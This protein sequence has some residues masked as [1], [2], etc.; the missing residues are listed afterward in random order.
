MSK[1]WRKLEKGDQALNINFNHQ[2]SSTLYYKD[3]G[4]HDQNCSTSKEIA[5]KGGSFTPNGF[6]P[7]GSCLS[8]GQDREKMTS[9]LMRNIIQLVQAMTKLLLVFPGE[10]LCIFLVKL[11]LKYQLHVK[12]IALTL[13]LKTVQSAV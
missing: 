5:G 13:A 9:R 8:A 10:D 3:A 2:K 4:L 11:R 6:P 1:P 12:S 7:P